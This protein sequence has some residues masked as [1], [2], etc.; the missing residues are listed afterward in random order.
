MFTLSRNAYLFQGLLFLLLGI[1]FVAAPESILISI[2]IYLGIIALIPGVV[3]IVIGLTG[4]T[5]GSVLPVVW[6]GMLALLGLLLIVKPEITGIIF[7]LFIGIWVIFS[8]VLQIQNALS[9][10]KSGWSN[11]WLRL[12]VGVVLIVFGLAVLTNAFATT[13]VLTIWFG[14][15]MI[16]TGVY[17]LL[18]AIA[19]RS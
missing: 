12:A 17:Y 2:S 14:V 15:L 11:W 7:A 10:K 8:G 5:G 16:A 19:A 6:G 4:R 13:V 9:M 3:M 18:L 1:L